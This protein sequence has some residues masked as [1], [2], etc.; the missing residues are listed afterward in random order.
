[1]YDVVNQIFKVGII[2]V[3]EIDVSVEPIKA[4]IVC[5]PDKTAQAGQSVFRLFHKDIIEH[6]IIHKVIL[7]NTVCK[8]RAAMVVVVIGAGVR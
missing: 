5:I 8:I 1:M 3:G 7:L 6:L 4:G 2:D